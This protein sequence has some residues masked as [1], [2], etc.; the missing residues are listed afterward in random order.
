MDRLA[1]SIMVVRQILVLFVLVRIQVGQP[2]YSDLII[3]SLFYYSGRIFEPRKVYASPRNISSLLP[4]ALGEI[5]LGI[6]S[7]FLLGRLRN[8]TGHSVNLCSFT[9]IYLPGSGSSIYSS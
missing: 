8:S 9:C 2:L 1:Y 3:R 4:G 7:A 5:K 6:V